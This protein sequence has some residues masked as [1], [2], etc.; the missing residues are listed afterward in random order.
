[1]EKYRSCSEFIHSLIGPYR[2]LDA[3]SEVKFYDQ[4]LVDVPIPGT[5]AL[6]PFM[7]RDIA[8]RW[9][10][11]C[12]NWV[13]RVPN[14]KLGMSSVRNRV[15]GVML[16][17]YRLNGF[18]EWGYNFWATQNTR[19]YLDPLNFSD[20]MRLFGGDGGAFAVFPGQSGKMI[21]ADFFEVFADGLQDQRAL[22]LLER[23]IGRSKTLRLIGQGLPAPLDLHNWPDDTAWL[24]SLRERINARIE[25][26]LACCEA[27]R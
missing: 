14:R 16:W 10:Y 27:K 11:Y 22:E 18:L 4:G 15:L 9:V 7:E 20:L 21:D 2:T 8:E 25:R 26:E 17:L 13:K 24:V 5:D 23:K 19:E 3:L 6:E 12:G 1:L